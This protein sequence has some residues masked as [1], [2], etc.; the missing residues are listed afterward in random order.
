M[1]I[2]S[3]SPY[4]TGHLTGFDERRGFS[5]V[6]SSPMSIMGTFL[7]KIGGSWSKHIL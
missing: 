4:Q 2:W 1:S 3:A 7:W 5:M 6:V